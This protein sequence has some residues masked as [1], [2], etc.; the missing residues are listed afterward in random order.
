MEKPKERRVR[1]QFC[2]EF[3]GESTEG[4]LHSV[5]YKRPHFALATPEGSFVRFISKKEAA[6]MGIKADTKVIYGHG[7]H[8][9]YVGPTKYDMKLLF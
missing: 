4:V 1:G 6:K 2:G 7:G 9:G 5:Y 3:R 8:G